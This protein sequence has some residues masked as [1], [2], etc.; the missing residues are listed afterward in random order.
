MTTFGAVARSFLWLAGMF[1]PGPRF[2]VIFLLRLTSLAKIHKG[3]LPPP[4]RPIVSANGCPTEKISALVDIYLRPYLQQVRSYLK[5]TTDFL[6]K[7]KALGDIP[8]DAILGTM[9]VT[10]LYTN[11][12]NC[13]GYLSIYSQTY[14]WW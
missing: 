7:L 6:N 11:I 4:G 3:T 12:P 1:G 5:D 10:S 2:L 14:G 13:K 8:R 9:D